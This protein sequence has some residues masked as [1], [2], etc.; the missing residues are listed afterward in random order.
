M[1]ADMDIAVLTKK[2]PGLLWY[3]S[4]I[5][6]TTHTTFSIYLDWNGFVVFA[7]DTACD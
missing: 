3:A 7:F 2:K 5:V 6:H 1:Y 4:H